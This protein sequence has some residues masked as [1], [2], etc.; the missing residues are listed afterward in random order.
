MHYPNG[1][2]MARHFRR[3]DGR[4]FLANKGARTRLLECNGPPSHDG[5]C[6]WPAYSPYI[7]HYIFLV[8]I[9]V[10]QNLII[11]HQCNF[12]FYFPTDHKSRVGILNTLQEPYI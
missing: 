12:I 8:S 6:S 11:L 5:V 10:P 1:K 2:P 3:Q 7:V 4:L 9:L